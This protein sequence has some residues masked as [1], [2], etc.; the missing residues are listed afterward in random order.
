MAVFTAIGAA[1]GL[2]GAAATVG[3]VA[4]AA[5]VAGAVSSSSLANKIKKAAASQSAELTRQA[6]ER[7]K[8]AKLVA[9]QQ[10][11]E[12]AESTERRARL[13]TGRKGLLYAGDA[14]GVES[15]KTTL[16]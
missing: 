14:T 11:R 7:E 6:T 15:T 1:L 4:V 10:T 9:E 13:A 12:D 8:Q 3:G 2:A 5:S 16:G